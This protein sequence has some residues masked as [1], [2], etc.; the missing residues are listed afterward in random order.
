MFH[1]HSD[2]LCSHTGC[3]IVT[4]SNEGGTPVNKSMLAGI[5]IGVAAALG[6]AAVASL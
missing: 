3:K 5:G 4:N 1:P 2:W 6:V